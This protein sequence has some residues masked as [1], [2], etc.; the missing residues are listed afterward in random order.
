[1]IFEIY[2]ENINSA[3]SEAVR[4]L[5]MLGKPQQ[6]RNGPVV[7]ALDPVILTIKRPN[8]RVLF[9]ADRDCNPFFHLMEFVWML[10]GCRDVGF[11]EYYNKGYRK[12]AEADGTVHGAYGYRWRRHFGFDQIK[13]VIAHI[14][15]DPKSRRAVLS[16]WSPEEDLTFHAGPKLA[17][18]DVPCN[19]HIYF[20]TRWDDTGRE[21]LDMTVCNRSNDMFWGM[22]GANV[23]HMTYLHELVA[24]GCNMNMGFYRVFTN[25]LHAYVEMPGFE[26]IW[27]RTVLPYDPYQK[28][29]T[30]QPLLVGY[31]TVEDLMT[32]AVHFVYGSGEKLRTYWFK[33]VALPMRVAWEDRKSLQGDGIRF[34]N[35]ITATDWRLAC[36]E[37]VQR[38][39]SLS[40]IST[41]P[42]QTKIGEQSNSCTEDP[43]AKETGMDTTAT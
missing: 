23:V 32:D 2:G 26:K 7:T 12:Y 21:Y 40:A 24:R 13:T 1:M 33:Q 11:I 22:L 20:R 42:S 4:I 27:N 37:W 29:V 8:E 16:M 39:M 34:I 35:Q 10:A 9:D 43:L 31:E 25:N 30:S 17:W 41:E 6:S 18:N 38:R 5:P 19:T 14:K 28:E 3:Y 15:S 36:Q